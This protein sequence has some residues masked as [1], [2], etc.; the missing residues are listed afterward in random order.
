MG[1]DMSR[2]ARILLFALA[3]VVTLA[4]ISCKKPV[5]PPDAAKLSSSD[6]GTRMWA[7]EQLMRSDVST[8]HRFSDNTYAVIDKA[9]VDFPDYKSRKSGRYLRQVQIFKQKNPEDAAKA[10]P[11]VFGCMVDAFDIVLGR[12]GIPKP[13]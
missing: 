11:V 8:M 2:L 9:L 12:D 6:F 7:I 5:A 13:K 4:P 1:Y 3:L 10:D